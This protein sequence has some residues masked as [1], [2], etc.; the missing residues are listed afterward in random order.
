MTS[1]TEQYRQMWAAAH[2]YRDYACFKAAMAPYER[3]VIEVALRN[4]QVEDFV[5]GLQVLD[6]GCGGGIAS[7]WYMEVLRASHRVRHFVGVDVSATALHA[8]DTGSPAWQ[9]LEDI[10]KIQGDVFRTPWAKQYFNLIIAH[11][12]WYGIP[13]RYV[14]TLR[15]ALIPKGKLIVV[16]NSEDS[17]L[18]LLARQ[19]LKRPVTGEQFAAF[20]NSRGI[21]FESNRFRVAL[22]L[23]SLKKSHPSWYR[24]LMPSHSEREIEMFLRGVTPQQCVYS[25]LVIRLGNEEKC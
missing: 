6:V 8:F 11:H 5:N 18:H 22:D 19:N 3:K 10:S 13:I 25:D 4:W 24:Y 15:Q 20:V 21:S 14:C 2:S 7:Q 9:G 1:G 23:S 12:S 16:L 17:L